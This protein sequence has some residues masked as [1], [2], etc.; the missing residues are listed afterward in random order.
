MS[1]IE[2]VLSQIGLTQ[3]EIKA[4][5][6]LLELGESK[7]GQILQ[8][9]GLN[10]GKIYEI[11]DSLQKKGLVSYIIKS[12]VKY[13]SPADPKRVLDYLEEK[14]ETLVKQEQDYKN[15]LPDLLKKISFFK[16]ETKIE[17]FTG[18]KGMKTAYAKEL[19]F[20]I[21]SEIYVVGVTHPAHYPSQVTKYFI[22][23]HY[24]QREKRK[25]K[26]K[27]LLCEEARKEKD[28][29]EKT[30]KIRYLPYGSMITINVIANL[31]II[32]MYAEEMIFISIESQQVAD[33][34]RNQFDLLWKIAK[35]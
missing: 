11:L 25:Y 8:K 17:I 3:T 21:G 16:P 4:Y 24:P 10:S 29:A 31:S 35:P 27:R 19:E 34:F 13:F 1:M 6:A 26:I 23:H 2:Q 9:S 12:G 28:Y 7:S 32:G 22:N 5:M 14:K 18:F 33:N 20:P 15:I 30:A